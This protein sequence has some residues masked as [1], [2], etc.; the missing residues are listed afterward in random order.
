M[1][2]MDA[3]SEKFP[4]KFVYASISANISLLFTIYSII[5]GILILHFRHWDPEILKQSLGII[6]Y[7]IVLFGTVAIAI[8]HDLMNKYV[9]PICLF[10]FMLLPLIVSL[11]GAWILIFLGILG[12][13]FTAWSCW[14]TKNASSSRDLIKLL[15]ASFFLPVFYFFVVN[16]C[17]YADIYSDLRGLK[18]DLHKDTLFH[19]AII[20]MLARFGVPSTGLDGVTP[21]AYHISVHRWVAANLLVLGGETP[22]LIAIAKQVALIPAF[23]FTVVHVVNRLSDRLSPFI[24]TLGFTFAIFWLTDSR[25]WNSYLLSESYLFSL[26]IFVAMLPVGKF[27]IAQSCKTKLLNVVKPWEIAIA[28][29]AIAACWAAKISTGIILGVYL[30]VCVGS[31][32]FFARPRHIIIAIFTWIGLSIL[33]LWAVNQFYSDSALT[34]SISPFHFARKYTKVFSWQIIIFCISIYAFSLFKSKN[35]QELLSPIRLTLLV[36]FLAGQTPGIFI[37]L[38]GGSAFYFSHPALLVALIYGT[39]ALATFWSYQ[40]LEEITVGIDNRLRKIFL[41]YESWKRFQFSSGYVFLALSLFIV[42]LS[43]SYSTS[44]SKNIR[45]FIVLVQ[46]DNSSF[47]ATGQFSLSRFF[48]KFQDI[49]HDLISP[50]KINKNILLLQTPIGRIKSTIADLGLSKTDKSL[51][52]YIPPSYQD[53]WTSR[54]KCWVSSFT[55][56]ALIGLPLLNGVRNGLGNCEPVQHYGLKDYGKSSL[57]YQLSPTDICTNAKKLG[58]R[59]VYEITENKSQMHNC[60]EI[61]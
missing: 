57:N 33:G 53:F 36:T 39:S 42:L 18:G 41:P 48:Y 3:H 24:T 7:P 47:P 6:A 5:T 44:Y 37:K 28:L 22:N 21:I 34:F 40:S 20:N 51:A 61:N 43:S 2:Y 15:S 8:S 46:Q 55:V 17:D 52:I 38:G 27:W 56:P 60:V 32:K 26:L 9:I 14:L 13:S 19:S 59:K 16:G 54:P 4:D 10:A 35:E 29:I 25:L 58:F 49:F 50:P 23:F 11:I 12:I 31:P 30:I 45:N 1:T